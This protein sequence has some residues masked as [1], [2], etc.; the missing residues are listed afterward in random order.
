MNPAEFVMIY[1]EVDR[2]NLSSG[3]YASRFYVEA[4]GTNYWYKET[5]NLVMEV[6]HDT[7]ESFL[8]V[9][10]TS[11]NFGRNSS[12]QV[13]EIRNGGELPLE[14]TVFENP[15]KTWITNVTPTCGT[16]YQ[17]QA[18]EA[19]VDISRNGLG[20]GIYNGTLSIDSNGGFKNVEISMEVKNDSPILDV[21]RSTLDFGPILTARRF[22]I[23]NRGM[24]HLTWNAN[25]ATNTPW[26]KTIVPASGGIN[27][28]E[29][30]EVVVIVDRALSDDST[31]TSHVS[32]NTNAGNRN[33]E[34][35]AEKS[36]HP[37][38]INCGG[39]DYIDH[40]DRTWFEDMHYYG[41]TDLVQQFE[42]WGTE[43]D[44][45]YQHIRTGDMVYS[46]PLQ[47]NGRYRLALHFIDA[48]YNQAQSRVFHVMVEDSSYYPFLDIAAEVPARTPLV[49]ETL[50]DIDDVTLNIELESILDTPVIA[51]IELQK[52]PQYP[53]LS[54]HNTVL[55]FGHEETR[56]HFVVR[57]TGAPA[58]HWRVQQSP[59]CN[60][61][62]RVSPSS[63]ITGYGYSD[64]VLVV[65]D[66]RRQPHGLFQNTLRVDSN[67]GQGLV[68]VSMQVG[69]KDPITLRINAGGNDYVDTAGNKWFADQGYTEGGWGHLGGETYINPMPVGGTAEDPLYQSERW[70]M[71]GYRF[72]VPNGTYDVVLHF[73]EIYFMEPQRRVMD[74]LIEGEL[75]LDD[76][77]I[78]SEV[79]YMTPCVKSFQSIVNN[80]TLD[81]EFNH[82]IDDPKISAIEIISQFIIQPIPLERGV[83]CP[84]ADNDQNR[85]IPQLVEM[86]QNFPNPFNMETLI[87]F[88]LPYSAHVRLEI[89]N[90]L[91][92]RIAVLHDSPLSEGMYTYAWQG[93]DAI[94]AAVPSGFY[95]YAIHVIPEDGASHTAMHQVNKMLLL[96]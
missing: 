62:R 39:G 77:D 59:D 75:K 32:V 60:W 22:L 27:P 89:Y 13:F 5:V 33:V 49:K 3:E 15:D 4:R 88:S 2:S 95:L 57:N 43:D 36:H 25:S 10:K 70:G 28:A 67:G 45:I 81:I 93:T 82:V 91:G 20:E 35:M 69:T 63:G 23:Y 78:F 46:I 84:A 31:M 94:G 21:S 34:I 1:V 96:K 53:C 7:S 90:L 8:L 51:G 16:L 9:D 42:V 48:E 24:A 71:D 64:S 44:I 6:E 58:L 41:G 54:L 17:G 38:L 92:R 19:R 80:H 73:A 79:G 76:L 56:L 72:D 40:A 14:F 52:I 66:R 29:H 30:Q 86:H 26:L 85:V 11:L 87:S 74:V 61:I 55:D 47:E 68:V 37:L 83:E 65:V 50:V 18:A 12:T